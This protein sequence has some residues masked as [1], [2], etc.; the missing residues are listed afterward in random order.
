MRTGMILV[1]DYVVRIQRFTSFVAMFLL[2]LALCAL[3][4]RPLTL[5]T[6]PALLMASASMARCGGGGGGRRGPAP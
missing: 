6:L 3:L 1:K 4:V 5:L 2:A